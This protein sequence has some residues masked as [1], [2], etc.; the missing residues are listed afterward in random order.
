MAG[1]SDIIKQ[2]SAGSQAAKQTIGSG[3][4]KEQAKQAALQASDNA[5]SLRNMLNPFIQSAGD[6]MRQTVQQ[7]PQAIAPGMV[8]SAG[9]EAKEADE[10]SF[11]QDRE[12]KKKQEHQESQNI[13]DLL[14]PQAYATPDEAGFSGSEGGSFVSRD[15]GIAVQQAVES[16]MSEDEAMKMVRKAN[17]EEAKQMAASAAFTMPTNYGR[18]VPKAT[19]IAQDALKAGKLSDRAAQAVRE[20]TPTNAWL[21]QAVAE[22]PRAAASAAE[23]AGSKVSQNALDKALK[24]IG[25]RVGKRPEINYGKGYDKAVAERFTKQ[26]EDVQNA[27][28]DA[29]ENAVIKNRGA[30]L[31]PVGEDYSIAMN[32]LDKAVKTE[33][34]MPKVAGTLGMLGMTSALGGL[35]GLESA[36]LIPMGEGIEPSDDN[37][38]KDGNLL[39]SIAGGVRAANKEASESG[40]VSDD[41]IGNI[42][43]SIENN[44]QIVGNGAL[45]APFSMEQDQ[46][47]QYN[48]FW[49]TDEGR[50][51][52]ADLI[53]SGYA[54]DYLTGDRGYYN[55]LSSMDRELASRLINTIPTWDA[56]YSAAGV[57][58]NDPDSI[59]SYMW[60]EDPI[61]ASQIINNDAYDFM[62]H[63]VSSSDAAMILPYLM[64]GM[65]ASGLD[66]NDIAYAAYMINAAN[67]TLGFDVDDFNKLSGAAGEGY[68]IGFLDDDASL[69]TK[70]HR[71]NPRDNYTWAE[72][73]PWVGDDG[74][75]LF[76]SQAL[77]TAIRLAEEQSGKKAGIKGRG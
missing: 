43:N 41:T 26:T 35:T 56:R 38:D 22:T 39:K 45:S 7:V 6:A 21:K 52:L 42:M 71:E 28:A 14:F 2:I 54:E 75:T 44:A 17:R 53:S 34:S 77:D 50:A 47:D 9:G 31:A 55:F 24:T 3:G 29:V 20:T 40:E 36:G 72:V 15:P 61:L 48:A 19:E 16:G 30:G 60:L 46:G 8:E 68:S 66:A 70:S 4:S 65:S 13:L 67:G 23:E 37:G 18:L 74:T 10:T 73:A 69:D 76:D 58:I 12:E 27:L 62:S 64:E 57:D 51:L 25:R 5:A 11:T 32:I 1:L 63:G 59:Y 49:N 33:N